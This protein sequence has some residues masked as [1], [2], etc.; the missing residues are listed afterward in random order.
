M[1]SVIVVGLARSGKD[2]AADFL[3]EKFGF[4]KIVLS[5]PLEEECIKRGLPAT[6]QNVMQLGDELRKQHG[7]DFLAKIAIER[8]Q[9]AKKVVF[10]GPR[11]QEE[12]EYIKSESEKCLVVKVEADPDKRFFRRSEADPT[13]LKEFMRRDFVDIRAKGLQKVLNNAKEKVL[14]NGSLTE[15]YNQIEE[16]IKKLN[17]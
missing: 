7:M 17:F 6:K 8:S 1:I 14:N 4:K 2:A 11:S 12:V 15:L 3:V 9:G 13:D 10:V 5:K 16:L